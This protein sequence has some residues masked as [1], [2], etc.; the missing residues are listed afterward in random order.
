ML[1][2]LAGE[3]LDIGP[4][5]QTLSPP[6]PVDLLLSRA[7]HLIRLK[8]YSIRTEKSYLP[9]IE[10]YIRFHNGRDPKEMGG[11]EIEAFLSIWQ[12]T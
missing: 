6:A 1:S 4:S 12:W 11:P 9:W 8:H 7:R 10:R 3:N 5:L 2:A